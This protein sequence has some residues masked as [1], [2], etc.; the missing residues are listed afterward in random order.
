M[1]YTTPLEKVLDKLP[2][3][4]PYGKGFKACCPAHDDTNPSLVITPTD[5]GKVLLKCWAGL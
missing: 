3:H 4:R 2:D 5:D 1:S